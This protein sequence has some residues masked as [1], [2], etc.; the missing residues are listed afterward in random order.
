MAQ[1][2]HLFVIDPVENLNLKLDSSLRLAK[3]LLENNQECFLTTPTDITWLGGTPIS[4][5]FCRATQ[6]LLGSGPTPDMGKSFKVNLGTF[7]SI[8]MRKDPPYD[9]DYISCT[10][11]LAVAERAGVKVYNNTEALRSI[12][13][14]L[15]IFEFPQYCLPGVV[16]F[17]SE[18]LLTFAREQANGDI[19]IKPL[20]LFGG[21][22]VRRLNLSD[23]G[24]GKFAEELRKE[25]AG[26]TQ[27]RLVQAFNQSIFQGE[28]R[29]FACCGQILSWC[30]KTPHNGEYLA[31][32]GRGASLNT[33]SPREVE[34][35]MVQDVSHKLAAKGIKMVGF[36][37]IGGYLSEINISSPRLLTADPKSEASTYNKMAT[38]ILR[39]LTTQ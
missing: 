2:K 4:T 24:E 38:L 9:L 21:R 6:L 18:E 36:D 39:D 8:H 16:S 5:P 10:W 29:V 7:A 33:Y 30:L 32:T 35:R 28:L 3:A 17:S 26:D 31:N 23:L 19:I 27:M 14:K 1:H 11:M 25:T 37:I 15:A 13:E 12:N 34:V 22:G 20:T